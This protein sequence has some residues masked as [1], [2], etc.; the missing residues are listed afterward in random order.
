VALITP[1]CAGGTDDP[2]NMQW[3]TVLA[4]AAKEDA[5]GRLCPTA[6]ASPVPR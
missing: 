5:E 1:R 4:A 3:L 2:A 6:P